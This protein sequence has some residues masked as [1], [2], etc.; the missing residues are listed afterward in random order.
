MSE[1]VQ[2][3]KGVPVIR[4]FLSSDLEAMPQTV[5]DLLGEYPT[6]PIASNAS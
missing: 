5:L 3:R 1:T 6:G 2:S 4:L